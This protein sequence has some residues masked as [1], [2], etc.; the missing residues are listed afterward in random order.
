VPTS[1]GGAAPGV[2]KPTTS[3][4]PPKAVAALEEQTPAAAPV[5]QEVAT[6][7]DY[8]APAKKLEMRR[9]ASPR[10][11]GSS[12]P[13]TVLHPERSPVPAVP[14]VAITLGGGTGRSLVWLGLVLV[15][16]TVLLVVA[17]LRQRRAP[18]A[19]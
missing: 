19:P 9:S 12:A 5:L 8:G 13:A 15:A 16:T 2:E 7:S 1:S 14:S 11:R 10:A 18:A 6:S 3:K 4:L 17:T